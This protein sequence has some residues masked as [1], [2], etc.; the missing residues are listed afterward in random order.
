[1]AGLTVRLREERKKCMVIPEP[2]SE[3]FFRAFRDCQPS[4]TRV[5]ILGQDWI[6]NKDLLS[7]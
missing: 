5:V 1:M 4:D 3:D 7:L 2:G 6:L